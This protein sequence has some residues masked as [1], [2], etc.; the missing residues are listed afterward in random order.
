MP[1]LLVIDRYKTLSIQ[2]IIY[3]PNKKG[4]GK[5]ANYSVLFSVI[6]FA[7]GHLAL[8]SGISTP[9]LLVQHVSYTWLSGYNE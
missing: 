7:N 4:R 3:L 5:I 2:V 9:V 1:S 6:G 8:N